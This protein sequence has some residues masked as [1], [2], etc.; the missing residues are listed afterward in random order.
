M[1]RIIKGLVYDTETARLVGSHENGSSLHR[2]KT[3][4]YF[5]VSDGKIHPCPFLEAKRW[6]MD[7]LDT[8]AYLREFV[9][10]EGDELIHASF[11]LKKSTVNRLRRAAQSAGRQL[12]EYLEALLS[13]NL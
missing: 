8:T 12:S 1:R 6:A 3:G 13:E 11:Y 10:T 7:N 5:I 4:E 9:E 2:K